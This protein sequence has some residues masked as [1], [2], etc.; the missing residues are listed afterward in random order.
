MD[1]APEEVGCCSLELNLGLLLRSD[2]LFLDLD[3]LEA[4]DPISVILGRSIMFTIM[5]GLDIFFRTS[6][7][8]ESLSFFGILTCFGVTVKWFMSKSQRSGLWVLGLPLLAILVW[9]R[10]SGRSDYRSLNYGD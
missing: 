2:S 4:I 7:Q 10:G 5:K 6:I 1:E 8:Q 3:C 9:R